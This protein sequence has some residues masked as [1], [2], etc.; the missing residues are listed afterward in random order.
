MPKLNPDRDGFD[1]INVG[2]KGKTVLGRD[3]S[4]FA[5]LPIRIPHAGDFKSIEGYW[6]W[7]KADLIRK[8]GGNINEALWESMHTYY[9]YNAK[10]AGKALLASVDE[11]LWD[12]FPT[13]VFRN[14]I[15]LALKIKLSTFK[16]LMYGLVEHT[17][18]LEHYYVFGDKNLVT[19]SGTN[20]WVIEELERLRM[21][22]Y[23]ELADAFVIRFHDED[24]VVAVIVMRGDGIT[25]QLETLYQLIQ[26]LKKDGTK[27]GIEIRQTVQECLTDTPLST[28]LDNIDSCFENHLLIGATAETVKLKTFDLITVVQQNGI[29]V[30][31]FKDW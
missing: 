28:W 1:H 23:F 5:N 6:Y 9:G 24:E 30:N 17:L 10:K 4:N 2:S 12:K 8:L 11:K 14:S 21:D 19:R 22:L 31:E 15:K 16:S 13:D 20:L 29:P 7:L 25:A 26:V 3:L 27:Q 18:P